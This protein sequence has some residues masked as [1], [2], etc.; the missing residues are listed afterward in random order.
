MT[1]R[2]L[3]VSLRMPL[4]STSGLSRTSSPEPQNHAAIE[5]SRKTCMPSYLLEAQKTARNPP[6][7]SEKSVGRE[8]QGSFSSLYLLTPR[9]R[10]RG[11]M[12]GV[13]FMN[14]IC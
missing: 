14:V 12:L 1:T 8:N 13:N 7:A 2:R 3:A 10:A 6:H 11:H 9:K 5:T 4:G